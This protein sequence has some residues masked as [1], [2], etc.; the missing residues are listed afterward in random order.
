M[1]SFIYVNISVVNDESEK[2]DKYDMDKNKVFEF[3]KNGI[4]SI[5]YNNYTC[6][7]RCMVEMCFHHAPAILVA[8]KVRKKS[9]EFLKKS[10]VWT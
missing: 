7:S 10:Y 2:F 9:T 3:S 8:S 5:L 6:N 4:L 1:I